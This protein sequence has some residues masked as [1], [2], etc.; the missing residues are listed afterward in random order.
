MNYFSSQCGFVS[1]DGADCGS[2]IVEGCPVNLCM[3]HLRDA[4]RFGRDNGVGLEDTTPGVA[5]TKCPECGSENVRSLGKSQIC[6]DC[7]HESNLLM[8]LSTREQPKSST[9][10]DLPVVYYIRHRDRIKIGT[11]K[12]W[13]ARIANFPHD[14]LLALETG[15]YQR[16]SL[17]HKQFAALRVKGS[18][19]F[20]AH[21]ALVKAIQKIRQDN[22]QY[23]E[24]ILSHN[25]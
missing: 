10:S 17:R 11:S 9:I 24:E 14:E 16:E 21:P 19:W 15:S 4:Y 13:S 1:E 25:R 6:A 2:P 12:N 7:L 5:G 3:E 8:F 23:E 20:V 22:S 18:E